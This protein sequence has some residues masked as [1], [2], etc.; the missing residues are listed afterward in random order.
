MPFRS[1]RPT[2]LNI[3]HR[4]TLEKSSKHWKCSQTNFWLA[5][6]LHKNSP[7]VSQW[8]T[9]KIL[10]P[11]SLPVVPLWKSKEHGKMLTNLIVTILLVFSIHIDDPKKRYSKLFNILRTHMGHFYN[12]RPRAATVR[13]VW[14]ESPFWVSCLMP[15]GVNACGKVWLVLIS[16][17]LLMLL[18]IQLSIFTNILPWARVEAFSVLWLDE[19]EISS[20]QGSKLLELWVSIFSMHLVARF[21]EPQLSFGG[22]LWLITSQMYCLGQSQAHYDFK[23]YLTIFYSTNRFICEYLPCGGSRLLVASNPN[24]TSVD[25]R[26]YHQRVDGKKNSEYISKWHYIRI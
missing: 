6:P 13:E 12:P 4:E 7:M 14:W 25:K 9:Q 16:I 15:L 3:F 23:L 18:S 8:N 2:G 22:C 11:I 26:S 19:H 17:S 24:Q 1:G 5:C 20:R 21:D 10:R